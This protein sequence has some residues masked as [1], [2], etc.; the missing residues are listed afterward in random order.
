MDKLI[1]KK[2]KAVDVRCKTTI[3]MK[4]RINTLELIEEVAE[5]TKLSKQEVMERMVRFAYN[6]IE[7]Q[8]EN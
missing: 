1:F 7:Y 6:N 8:E 4:V 5:E 2:K 3:C